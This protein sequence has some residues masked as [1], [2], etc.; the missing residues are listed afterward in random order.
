MQQ[1]VAVKWL[2][3]NGNKDIREQSQINISATGKVPVFGLIKNI[4]FV[5]LDCKCV[6]VDIKPVFV[7][8]NVNEQVLSVT[9]EH[10]LLGNLKTNS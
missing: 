10:F 7:I 8:N 4:Y 5:D 3:L 9:I 1:A 2:I 6:D